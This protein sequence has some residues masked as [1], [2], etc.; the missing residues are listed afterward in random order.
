MCARH[1]P[2]DWRSHGWPLGLL[3]TVPAAAYLPAFLG[4]FQ[5]DD[6][7]VIVHNPAV[8]SWAAF[9][10]SMP[11]IRPFL[12]LSYTLNWTSGLGVLGFHA[13]YLA[14]HLAAVCCGYALGRAWQGWPT[15]T[16]VLTRRMALTTALL[17]ALHPA[18][19]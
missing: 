12:K 7:N 18:Q 1:A 19:T 9:V 8:H 13:V 15:S 11:G 4:A 5:F 2:I 17:F 3:L 10:A 14:C 6:Y 16:P